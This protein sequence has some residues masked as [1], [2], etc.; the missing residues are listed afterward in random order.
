MNGETTVD[1]DRSDC[2]NCVRIWARD[3]RRDALLGL[4]IKPEL[5]EEP[6]RA[7][8]V[9][10][11]RL[12][13]LERFEFDIADVPGEL[14]RAG[15]I[16]QA[17]TLESLI[18][19]LSREGDV[20]PKPE[21]PPKDL[22][23]DPLDSAAYYGLAGEIVK[24]IEPDTE[25][26]P[27]GILIQ[28]HVAF[29]SCVGRKPNFV[30]E[31]D[32]HRTNLFAALVGET[33]KGRKGTSWGRSRSLFQR[34]GAD[35]ELWTR[36]RVIPGG[37]SSGEGLIWL[38]HDPI[39]KVNK[40]GE[41]QLVE[42]GVADKR[43]LV[44]E[45]E[46]A[47]VLRVVGREGNTLS[48]Y[49]R[50]AWDGGDLQSC[51]KNSPAKATGA[52]ISVIGHI[53]AEELRRYLLESEAAGGWANRF[54]HV[55]VRR[56]KLLPHGG[57][58]MTDDVEGRLASRLGEAIEFAKRVERMVR[59]PEADRE[60]EA[61]YPELTSGWPGMFGAITARSEAQVLRLSMTYA[62]LDQSVVIRPEHL[63]AALALWE[64]AEASVRFVWGNALG[65]PIADEILEELRNARDHEVD[66]TQIRNL[67]GRHKA[68]TEIDRAIFL[69][70]RLRL[71]RVFNVET[72]GRPR[73]V[74]AL[75]GTTNG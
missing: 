64:Y 66:R 36:E 19:E 21:E 12:Y 35:V 50:C 59:S 68:T 20:D 14:R 42:S 43:L 41:E 71:I 55:C 65:D 29:G 56:S 5:C 75:G 73:Q 69:L 54:I 31:R 18:A 52:H 1:R 61:V 17:E 16:A 72:D 10:I 44:V 63:R 32:V 3:G 53:V 25:A 39:W 45:A 60:W 24:A 40:D 8:L 37:L 28:T 58:A 34:A 74:L 27:A 26:D 33:S 23:P 47:K 4:A 9:E 51:T 7:L 49:V 38:V 46:Y 57:S 15:K 30:V 22:W 11:H 13:H 62:L 48:S 70:V 6:Y 67:F 2:L